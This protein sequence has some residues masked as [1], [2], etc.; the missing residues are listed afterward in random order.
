M[1]PKAVKK[2]QTECLESP[3]TPLS[4]HNRSGAIL[5]TFLAAL[6]AAAAIGDTLDTTP[7]S[8][9][10]PIT[11]SGYAG[12]T[13]ELTNFPVLVKLAAGSPT[14]FDPAECAEDGSDLRFTTLDGKILPHEVDTWN[15]ADESYIWVGIPVLTN[16]TSF[17]LYYG[18][19]NPGPVSEE[20]L[21]SLAGYAG[22]WHLT[23]GHDSTTNGLDGTIV[24]SVTA[25]S[26]SKLGGALDFTSTRMSLGTTP[27]GDFANGFSLEAWCYPRNTS[28]KAIFGKKEAMS[29]RIEEASIRV[30]T[31]GVKDHDLANCSISANEWFHLGLTFLPNPST[32]GT[33]TIANQYKVYRD[34]VQKAS[35]GA[36]RIPNLTSNDEMWIGGNKWSD[37][38]FNGICDEFRLSYFIRSADW[39]K[40]VYDTTASPTIF[41]KLGA[42]EQA[43]PDAPRIDV[44]AATVSHSDAT[45]S[46][47]LSNVSSETVVSVF[48]GPDFSTLTELTLGTLSADGTLTRTATGLGAAT[49][50]WYARATTTVAG[51]AYAIK[52]GRK[53]F[54]VTYAKEPSSSYK[55]FT[56]T[57]SYAGTAIAGVPVPIRISETAIEGFH[58]ADVTETGFEFVDADGN[59][60]PWELDTWDTEGESVVWVKVP[61]YY[62]GA[63][64]TARYGA[65]FANLRPA[66]SD[67]WSA[68]T[69]VWHL[70][71]LDA[72]ASA[73][74]S[75]PN[76]TAVS[77]IDG[78]KAEASVADEKGV[79][80]KSVMISQSTS[81]QG[82]GYKLGGVFVPDAGAGSPLDLG[83]TFAISGWFKHKDFDY[84]YDKLFGKRK[85]ANNSESP[86][87]AFAI[88]IGNNGSEHNV[89]ACGAASTATKLNFKTSLKNSWSH[90]AFVYEGKSCRVYQNGSL[91]GTSTIVEVTNNNAPLCF[92]NL[93]GGYGN[94]TGDSA[95]AGWIDEVRLA[96][97]VLSAEYLAA[98]YDAVTN[99]V[100]FGSVVSV[101][102]GDPRI[103]APV[104]ERQQDGSFL[105][106][107][108]ISENEPMSGSVKCVVGG[109][110][111][112]MTTS[113]ASLPATYSAVVTGLPDGTYR[114][115]V[116]AQAEGGSVVARESTAVF[117]A[118]ALV[119]TKVVDAEEAT[120]S[121]G[122][123]R[124]SRSDTDPTG[125]PAISFDVVFSG[126]GL[127]AIVEPTVAA[128]TIPAGAAYVDVSVTPIYTTEVDADV[129]LTLSVSGAFVGTPSSGSITIVNS[130][131]DPSV[132]Y[133][134]TTGS[135][136]NHGGTPDLPKKTI[137]AAIESL[138]AI[139]QTLPCTVHVAPGLYPISHPIVVTNS[140][141]VIG[142][143]PDPSR[144]VVS[145]TVGAGYYNQDQRVFRLDHSEAFVAN[146][147][148]QKG[149]DYGHG[150]NLNIGSA[151]GMVSNCVVEAG[152]TRDN[153]KAG[154]A[155]LDAG[156]VTHT[157]FRKNN[158]SSGTVWWNGVTEGIL[159]L[160]GNSR[161]EN[162]LFD[163]NSQWVTVTLISVGGSAVL[164]NCSIVNTG[165]SATNSDY[166]VWSALKIDSG[167]TVQNV[168]I[169]GVTNTIDGAAC[170]PTGSGVANFLNGAFDGD[171]TG[172]PEGTVTGTAAEFFK[173]Y[174]NGDYTPSF[175]GPLANVGVEYEGMAAVDLAGK[176]RKA[177][178]HIDIG[179]YECQK[180]KGFF[181]LVQ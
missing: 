131:Y 165:L 125:L 105:V 164:R 176:K 42:V 146:L 6:C 93:T 9:K 98:E 16:E 172:L 181:I 162:C 14:G 30:T 155:W 56:A 140:I 133:V 79:L 124:V 147:T 163:N 29:V 119:V 1:E 8:K 17:I 75:Y 173:D 112:A 99:I 170:P 18:A 48:C 167:A 3:S 151:G 19:V 38:S 39:I 47:T 83:D 76:S 23:D 82:E 59:I 54:T 53:D 114:A 178:K 127:A 160:G 78:E 157:V 96:D 27:N 122:T 117:Y 77:G 89:T 68:Y 10:I 95:W 115:T 138:A 85:K 118:G 130:Q 69:G 145:N 71:D 41:A 80:G 58:Y 73:Y 113:D 28:T 121:P 110:E 22:V 101:E 180:V 168:V 34:G 31:P 46:V 166:S 61:S 92:G 141:S 4:S 87:G 148:M 171:V 139:V 94:G 135:D 116:R 62:E 102:M 81:K 51:V 52:S 65:T 97:G 129:A 55:H 174:A 175:S 149:Q 13:S 132:R 159:H 5:A 67:V 21:W 128:L 90:I 20:N 111:F 2:P 40:A 66:A 64:I 24:S 143:D 26:N 106:M 136:E 161:A 142:D 33:G 150:G 32:D 156:V 91:I 134:A 88:E 108:E 123:F 103:S 152:Y 84:Y 60:L 137:G 63:A 154:G 43:N 100:A 169:A 12:G 120:L 177:G 49:Y 144:V 57:I 45:F 36:S 72:S 11:I 179:C 109:M 86:N 44:T 74:G 70:G 158:T 25:T 153:G 15:A 7:F 107:A 126:P 50:V 104:I 37:Q 35:L